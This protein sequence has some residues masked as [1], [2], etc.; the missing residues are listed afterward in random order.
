MMGRR[1]TSEPR[2]DFGRFLTRRLDDTGLEPAELAR[3]ADLSVSHVYQL[4][5]GDRSDPR[6]TTFRKLAL[7]L[8]MSEAQLARESHQRGEGVPHVDASDAL[9]V[10]KATFFAIM[11]AFPS[12]VTIVTTLDGDGRPKGLTC[13]SVCSLSADPPLLLVCIDRRSSSLPALRGSGRFVV[14][15][16]LAGRGELSNRFSTRDADRW[17]GVPWRPT[18]HGLPWLH[19]DSLAFAECSLVQEMEAG[20]HVV[21][22]G[23]V[24]G[25][26]PPA[27]GTKPLMYFRRSYATWPH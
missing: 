4:M 8:G 10:D 6:G 12:G 18:R 19:A 11:S 2:S 20:D 22:V 26:Q 3:R 13:N 5:R 27:P 7:A 25:G 9:A 16:L 17:T 1:R 15:F 23:R 24:D 21:I 14:N